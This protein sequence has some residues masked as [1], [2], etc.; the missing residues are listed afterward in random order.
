V[1]SGLV[2]KSLK[3][4]SNCPQCDKESK[5]NLNDDILIFWCECGWSIEIKEDDDYLIRKLEEAIEESKEG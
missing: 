2:I 1:R 3:E 5:Y 4:N